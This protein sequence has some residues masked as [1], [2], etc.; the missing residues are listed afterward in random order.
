M[1]LIK[2]HQRGITAKEAVARLS[3]TSGVSR[4]KL[5]QAWV[6]ISKGEK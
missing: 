1:E 5:Y 4:K 3:K 2:L 6:R